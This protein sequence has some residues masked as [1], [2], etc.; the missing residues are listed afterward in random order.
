MEIKLII[1]DKEISVTIDPGEFLLDTLRR[2]GF[3]GAK[4]GCDTGYCGAC[5][6]LLDGKPVNSCMI[7]TAQAAGIPI[8]TIEGM[9]TQAKPTPLQKNFVEL[10]AVQCGYCT[11]GMLLAAK[12]LLER[13]SDP[14]DDEIKEAIGG[15]L[16]RC[17]G[18]VK[19]L[20][21]IRK[22]ADD[23]KGKGE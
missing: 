3:K 1:N 13:N 14:S 21:A 5:T 2:L 12:A 4:R 22:T 15:N 7:F 11:P 9:G 17:T 8:S 10:G 23:L 16:C 19:P 6:V 20:E 18:Y